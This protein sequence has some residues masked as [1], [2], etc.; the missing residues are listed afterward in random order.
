M[1]DVSFSNSYSDGTGNSSCCACAG[2]HK[3]WRKYFCSDKISH[4]SKLFKSKTEKRAGVIWWSR[5]WQELEGIAVLRNK[6]LVKCVS[7]PGVEW[8]RPASSM[9]LCTMHWVCMKA[10]FLQKLSSEAEEGIN[11]MSVTWGNL[12]HYLPAASS[13]SLL[14]WEKTAL[15]PTSQ[16]IVDGLAKVQRL[17]DP[18]YI[19]MYCE[20]PKNDL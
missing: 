1:P 6:I 2:W 10:D 20:L 8:F 12:F 16:R 3:L 18:Y 4:S 13:R 15:R 14:Q 5:G 9:N 17:L 19:W 11:R 7:F